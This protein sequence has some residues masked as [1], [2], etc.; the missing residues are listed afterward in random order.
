M[1]DTEFYRHLSEQD[2]GKT[3]NQFCTRTCHF[4]WRAL[5]RKAGTYPKVGPRHA[6]RITAEQALG[7]PLMPDEVVH[8]IDLDKHN[9]ALVNLAVF[10]DRATHN[11]CHAGGMS[12]DELRRYALASG[13]P[14]LTL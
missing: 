1:C 12:D 9:A 3:V 7:R 8:H 5:H 2:I 14:A 4:E 10:P 13:A 6:H 11:R